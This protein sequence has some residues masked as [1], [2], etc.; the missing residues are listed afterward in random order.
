MIPE[1]DILRKPEEDIVELKAKLVLL[2]NEIAILKR[3]LDMDKVSRNDF[4]DIKL[5]ITNLEMGLSTLH[6]EK[7]KTGIT[8]NPDYPLYTP[9]T[10]PKPTESLFSPSKWKYCESNLP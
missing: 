6:N 9:W 3:N 5:R 10:T 4:F 2:E 1:P 7:A 8:T